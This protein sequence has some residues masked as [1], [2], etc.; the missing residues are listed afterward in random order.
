MSV[1]SIHEAETSI[2]PNMGLN[3]VLEALPEA[4][5][6][7]DAKGLI[8]FF[9]SAAAS[10]WGVSPHLGKSEFCGSWKLFW[11]DGRPLPHHECPMATA[12]K[13]QRPLRGLEI[14]AERP[15]GERTRLLAYPSPIFAATGALIGAVNMLIDLSDQTLAD[16]SAL[17]HNA[18]VE[19]SDDAIVAKDLNGTIINWNQGAQRLFG[20]T[21]E[22]AIGK[23]VAM[24][25]PLDRTNEEPDILQRIRKGERIEHY[26]TVRRRKDGSLVEISL[27]VSPIRNTEG[28]IIGAAKIA[29]D[30]T[31]Q[32]KAEAQKNLLLREM[33][34]RVKNLFA[35]ANGVISLSVRS[36][37][38]SAELA[39]VVTARMNAL[40]KAHAL[41]L[42]TDGGRDQPTTLHTLIQTI[43]APYDDGNDHNSSRA[44]VTGPNISI[45]G[46]AVTSFALLL[47]EFAT[48]AA[49]YGALSS[50]EGR[51][52]IT[53]HVAGDTFTLVWNETNGPAIEQAPTS[54]GFGTLLAK[55]T[56]KGQL[57]GEITYDWRQDGLS[58]TLVFLL[59]SAF[60][61]L[62]SSL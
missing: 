27:S 16:E 33:D 34:H 4:I 17:R 3:D 43:I 41:T 9:N 24:L 56:V 23:P 36:T 25:I 11:P 22:E 20:Y 1:R 48:N 14:V 39:S 31:E 52:E 5:Y 18:I 30:I 37:T 51:L 49:K 29:R 26:E 53:S 12:L 28:R 40:A 44:F 13:E 15:D 61:S 10:L 7:T 57:Q 6:T 60:I 8:T 62:T 58:I 38:T 32:R 50:G 55:A 21:A 35:L 47:H 59:G 2:A 45:A 54:M 46:S 19:S 42:S